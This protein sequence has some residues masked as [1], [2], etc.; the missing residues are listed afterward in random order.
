MARRRTHELA[1]TEPS[2]GRPTAPSRNG[3]SSQPLKDAVFRRASNDEALMST[4]PQNEIARFLG[5]GEH[6]G[7]YTAWPGESLLTRAR[8]GDQAL[9]QALISVVNDRPSRAKMPDGLVGLDM[10]AFAR[11]TIGPMVRGLFSAVSLH[12]TLFAV[13]TVI[14]D[15]PPHRSGRAQLRHPAP[16][17]SI[18]RQATQRCGL[19]HAAQRL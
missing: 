6:D 11:K 7:L 10:E 1:L 9:R 4:S 3:G 8:N 5:S 12:L 2:R 17:R 13:G 16:T 19:S 15:R 18:W 14:T